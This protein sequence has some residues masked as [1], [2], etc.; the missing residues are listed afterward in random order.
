[1]SFLLCLLKCLKRSDLSLFIFFKFCSNC[2]KV[3]LNSLRYSLWFQMCRLHA[4]Q[5]PCKLRRG[6]IIVPPRAGHR[7]WG[8]IVLSRE[9]TEL[10]RTIQSFR[11]KNERIKR[12]LNNIGTICKGT[13]RNGKCLKRTFKI[14]FA[15]LLS[16][17]RSKSGT[18]MKRL[19]KGTRTERS[20]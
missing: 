15:F 17:T 12:V 18:R 7:S 2:L 4:I 6:S 3:V 11:K 9:Q 14:R 8:T 5:L 1:M 20:S 19:K 16:R 13:E 10:S